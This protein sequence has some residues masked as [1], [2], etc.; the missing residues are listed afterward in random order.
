MVVQCR[1][2][3]AQGTALDKRKIAER[4]ALK[5]GKCIWLTPLTPGGG[6]GHP[7]RRAGW[8]GCDAPLVVGFTTTHP[9]PDAGDF[10][11]AKAPCTAWANRAA[12][13]S[14]EVREKRVAVSTSVSRARHASAIPIFWRV[15]RNTMVQFAPP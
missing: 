9:T 7:I 11:C 14:S 10:R 4:R 3:I 1:M 12:S 5:Q 15:V 6:T 8:D 13:A 2:H